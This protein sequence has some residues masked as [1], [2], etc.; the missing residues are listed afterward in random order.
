MRKKYKHCIP[1]DN[2]K[3]E[4]KFY[5]Y[6]A[7]KHLT[8]YDDLSHI[9]VVNMILYDIFG[10]YPLIPMLNR[11]VSKDTRLRNITLPAGTRV[12]TPVILVHQDSQLWGEGAKEFNRQRFSKGISKATKSQAFS[13]L[14]SR[15]F[16]VLTLQPQYGTHINLRQ[17]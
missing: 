1:T 9:K 2:L 5:K 17:L 8:I 14:C 3:Q 7:L 10:L 4:K 6:L 16:L 12:G 11:V 13:I 15:S